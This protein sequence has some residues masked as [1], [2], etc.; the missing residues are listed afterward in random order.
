[1]TEQ[2]QLARFDLPPAPPHQ[3][4]YFPTDRAAPIRLLDLVV[5]RHSRNARMRRRGAAAWRAA[6]NER[7]PAFSALAKLGEQC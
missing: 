2:E 4:V 7:K 3:K 1:M 6:V 5:L